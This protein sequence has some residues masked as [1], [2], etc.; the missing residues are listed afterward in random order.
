MQQQQQQQEVEG[1]GFRDD[2]KAPCYRNAGRS[3]LCVLEA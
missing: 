3:K 1:V 2:S